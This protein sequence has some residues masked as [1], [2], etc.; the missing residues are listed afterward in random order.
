MG[1]KIT[2]TH[3]CVLDIQKNTKQ[4]ALY[5]CGLSRA[6]LSHQH[7]RLVTHQDLSEALSVLED[8]QQQPLL[9]D[10]IVAWRVWQVGEGVDLRLKNGVLLNEATATCS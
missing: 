10:L 7:K 8:R 9:Q 3:L 1:Q 4:S 6:R 2:E 5:L